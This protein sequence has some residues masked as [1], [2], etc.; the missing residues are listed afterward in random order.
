MGY[1]YAL[2]A[3]LEIF[4]SSIADYVLV[5]VL[6]GYT[7]YTVA[8]HSQRSACIHK[9]TSFLLLGTL[10]CFF[11][12]FFFNPGME[13]L[14]VLGKYLSCVLIYFLMSIEADTLEKDRRF[15]QILWSAYHLLFYVSFFMILVGS[16]RVV[17]GNS[18]TL[19]GAYFYKTDYAGFLFQFMILCRFKFTDV[20]LEVTRIKGYPFILMLCS[21]VLI[22]FTNSRIY[23]PLILVFYFLLIYEYR[24]ISIRKLFRIRYVIIIGALGLIGIFVL[25][26]IPDLLPQLDFIGLSFEDGLLTGGNTQGRNVIWTNVLQYFWNSS[27]IHHLLGVDLVSTPTASGLDL[28]SHSSFLYILFSFGYIGAVLFI[29]LFFYIFRI[30]FRCGN[31]FLAYTLLLAV[32]TFGITSISQDCIIFTQ[33]TAF[34]YMT[35]AVAS[36]NLSRKA[37]MKNSCSSLSSRRSHRPRCGKGAFCS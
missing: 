24:K 3:L 31:S 32:I 35:L 29:A 36:R 12:S 20:R 18:I 8:R 13:A 4:N 27:T 23:L 7:I 9:T 34:L 25:T 30:V 19:R 5:G 10:G 28:L 21:S 22:V 16:G 15:F 17:W 33:Q 26:V 6:I 14:R 1:V 2:K 11:I 37:G